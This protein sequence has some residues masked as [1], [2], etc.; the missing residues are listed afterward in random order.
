V[1]D[2]STDIATQSHMCIVVRFYD[3]DVQ[4]MVSKCLDLVPVYNLNNPEKVN[5]GAT[6][7]IYLNVL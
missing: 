3:Y 4:K 5:E 7:K 1:V 6:A 2:E